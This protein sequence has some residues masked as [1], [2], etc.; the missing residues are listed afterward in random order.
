MQHTVGG[1]WRW[2]LVCAAALALVAGLVGAARRI[3]AGD[4]GFSPDA[5]QS[6]EV[7]ARIAHYEAMREAIRN[8]QPTPPP[9]PARRACAWRSART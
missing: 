9:P 1:R 2:G 6:P 8:G 3:F 7:A 4:A 5:Y